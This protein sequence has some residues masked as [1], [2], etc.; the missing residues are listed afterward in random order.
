MGTKLKPFTSG[1]TDS[2]K[3]INKIIIRSNISV[4]FGY[5]D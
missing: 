1:L 2:K 3:N 4:P 5:I